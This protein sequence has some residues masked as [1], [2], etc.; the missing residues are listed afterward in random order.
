M[1]WMHNLKYVATVLMLWNRTLSISQHFSL[2]VWHFLE[3]KAGYTLATDQF[4]NFGC[5]S[6]FFVALV[7]WLVPISC[8]VCETFWC[9]GLK[10]MQTFRT[11][12]FV[13]QKK[14]FSCNVHFTVFYPTLKIQNLWKV[15][16]GGYWKAQVKLIYQGPKLRPTGRQ[17]D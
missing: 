15:G 13:N 6:L 12:S 11:R 2:I 3:Q 9:I 16:L 7:K 10:V 5:Q 14:P 1:T 4:R 17:C 8:P